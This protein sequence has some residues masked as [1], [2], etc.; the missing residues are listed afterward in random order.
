MVRAHG[1]I[2]LTAAVVATGLLPYVLYGLGLP[3]PPSGR[4]S[5]AM[6]GVLVLCGVAMWG[7]AF[8]SSQ[9]PPSP[10]GRLPRLVVLVLLL[11]GALGV[12]VSGV[13]AMPDGP[14]S[15]APGLVATVRTS[16]LVAVILALAFSSRV[17]ALVEG[18]WLVYPLLLSTG[19]K[20][21]LED[22]RTG[23]PATLVAGF[24]LYGLALVVGPRLSQRPPGADEGP[25]HRPPP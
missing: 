4:I 15:G 1:A 16:L 12:I 10:V 18:E 17:W 19:L 11:G 23:R 21:L 8:A 22:V 2:Y 13:V 24:A 5:I 14:L 3:V 9:G 7:L 20:F 25:P 6:P